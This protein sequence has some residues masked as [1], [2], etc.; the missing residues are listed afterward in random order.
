MKLTKPAEAF[1]LFLSSISPPWPSRHQSLSAKPLRQKLWPFCFR[2]IH[3]GTHRIKNIKCA[4]T[5]SIAG[6]AVFMMQFHSVCCSS[7]SSCTWRPVSSAQYCRS[8]CHAL[9]WKSI[10]FKSNAICHLAI[11]C[12]NMPRAWSNLVGEADEGESK[13]RG[14]LL[15]AEPGIRMDLSLSIFLRFITFHFALVLAI[16]FLQFNSPMPRKITKARRLPNYGQARRGCSA[17]S[18]RETFPCEHVGS[19]CSPKAANGWFTEWKQHELANCRVFIT[20]TKKINYIAYNI[21]NPLRISSACMY[22]S[23]HHPAKEK[24]RRRLARE[25]KRRLSSCSEYGSRKK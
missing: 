3:G 10:S 20:F 7:C 8:A 2:M 24:T 13:T 6:C 14:L 12:P 21:R 23:H 17:V 4:D 5:W 19:T 22:P 11:R 15:P 25:R 1:P 16:I 9:T 18:V